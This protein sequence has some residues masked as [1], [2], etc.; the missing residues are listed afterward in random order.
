MLASGTMSADARASSRGLGDALARVAS[1]ATVLVAVGAA[2]PRLLVPI[3]PGAMWMVAS[4]M[5]AAVAYA[6]LAD[7]VAHD[8]P[9]TPP[10]R[11]DDGVLALRR[12]S[13]AGLVLFALGVLPFVTAVALGAASDPSLAGTDVL[14]AML[15]TTL[16]MPS[17]IVA[18]TITGSPLAAFWPLSWIR[19][20]A[21]GPLAYLGLLATYAA[22]VTLAWASALAVER[23]LA[24]SPALA[25]F[26]AG[27]AAN[28]AW[29]AQAALVGSFVR[30]LLGARRG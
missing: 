11:G 28:L 24:P 8:R 16:Y 19:V 4:G 9:G 2:L 15:A 29:L 18:V 26:L 20:I 17:A 30:G 13:R 23:A 25:S 6:M 21:A 27:A 3:G 14:A 5:L 10:F 12:G 1:P 22:T 7:H